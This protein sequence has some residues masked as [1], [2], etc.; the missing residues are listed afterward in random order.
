[1]GRSSRYTGLGGQHQLLYRVNF[2]RCS[3]AVAILGQP[4]HMLPEE[5]PRLFGKLGGKTEVELVWR[6]P[7]VDRKTV[8]K[9]ECQNL[10]EE[11]KGTALMATGDMGAA[12]GYS[13]PFASSTAAGAQHNDVASRPS[14][15]G[16]GGDAG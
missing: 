15:A 1:M 11:G 13:K 16:S 14:I 7:R 10:Q 2:R 4:D 8:S 3:D 12:G 9:T 5:L 6:V